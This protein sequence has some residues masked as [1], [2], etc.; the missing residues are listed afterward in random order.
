MNT[1]QRIGV[2]RFLEV[3]SR[4]ALAGDWHADTRY[5]VAAIEHAARR[6]AT[7]L[8]HLGDFGY[9]FTDM[10]LDTLDDTLRRCGLVLGFVDGNHEDFDR[11]LAYPLADNGLRYLRE[12]I[13][14]LPRGWKWSWGSTQCLAL[15]GAYSIDRILRVEGTSWWPQEAITAEE[16]ETAVAG[17]TADAM[18]CHDCPA[19]VVVPGRPR[20]RYGFPP[21]EVA[22][23]QANRDRLRHVVD[24]VR[25]ARLWHGHFHQRH[26]ALLEGAGYR[27]V[28]DGLGKNNDPLDNNLV[29]V[30]LPDLGHHRWSSRAE[31]TVAEMGS[32]AA[33]PP[34]HRGSFR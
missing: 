7:V 2:D 11:L 14:H 3:P 16:A 34:A 29:V 21:S 8:I 13:V 24:Q 33:I 22:A 12:R 5:G 1:H 32:L 27:T 23:S 20:E 15:G 26:Q 30:N 6:N 19:G 17:G 25:P 10:Y 18:F 31:H 4:I 9:R 28:V